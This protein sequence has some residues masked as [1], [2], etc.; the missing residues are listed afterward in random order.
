MQA[1]RWVRVFGGVLFGAII[2]AVIFG[3]WYWYAIWFPA[4]QV[5]KTTID[6]KQLEAAFWKKNCAAGQYR[7]AT[8]QKACQEIAP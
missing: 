2:L 3:V 6:I 8:V 7:N 1:I 5:S 4:W